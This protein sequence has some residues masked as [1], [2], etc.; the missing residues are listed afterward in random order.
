[1][2][3]KVLV[4][5]SEIARKHIRKKDIIGRYGGE[6]FVF[7]FPETN[8]SQAFRILKRIH[9]ELRLFFT[10][11]MELPVTFSAGIVHVDHNECDLQNSN[12]LIGSV[13]RMLYRAKKRGR[14]RAV[15][16]S[17]EIL[18]AGSKK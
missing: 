17:G 13:D 9:N 12:D 18:F 7:I 14:N 16:E 8:Q 10:Q 15:F 11:Y 6:E 5:F 1:V 3:D 4:T 2:G